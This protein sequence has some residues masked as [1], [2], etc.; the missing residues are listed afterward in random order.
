MN[1]IRVVVVD[2]SFFMRQVISDIL[3]ADTGLE[4]VG[5]AS[6]GIKALQVIEEVH[7]DVVSLDLEMPHMDGLATL[8]QLMTMP[9][10]PKVV[11]VSSYTKEDAEVTFQCL[12]AGA[13]DFVLK[14]SGSIS[15]DMH[16]VAEELREKIK[17]AINVRVTRPIQAI[18]QKVDVI[19][20]RKR[21]KERG[22]VVIGSSTGGPPA[23][24]SILPLFPENFPLPV[25][26]AQHLPANFTRTFANR[27]SKS[28]LLT[29]KEAEP[30]ETVKPG[31]ILIAPGGFYSELVPN[32]SNTQLVSFHVYETGL[33]KAL[34]PSVDKLMLSTVRLF[35]DATIGIILTGM[36]EDG[37]YGMQIIKETNGITIV[38][39]EETS[40][41]YGMGRAVV[42][43]GYADHVIPLMDI[44]AKVMEVIYG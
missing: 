12:D 5:K 19:L 7:P 43:H 42:E 29:I 44:P 10:P 15:L 14:P 33:A 36:G 34:T 6:D 31:V 18:Q 27:I 25:V 37:L 17:A 24:E 41:V 22:I 26:V 13:V 21:L 32:E 28:C 35:G 40:A 9:N 11:M 4:V 2:D 1:K 23:L 38:Q 39:N 30:G 3:N 8:M 20:H 16:Q